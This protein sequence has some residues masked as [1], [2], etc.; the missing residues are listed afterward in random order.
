[1]S[2]RGKISIIGAGNVGATCAQRLVETDYADVVMV[3]I[4]EGLPQGKA[5]DIA[6]SAP[7]LG[8]NA[9]IAGT[10]DYR[11]TAGSDVVAITSG[12]ARKP[13]MTRDDLLRINMSIVGEV[14]KNVVEHSPEC[15]II[16]VTNPVE[17]MIYLALRTSHLP[18]RRVVG[19]SGVLDGARL[20][21]FIAAEL[22]AP[23]EAVSACVLGQHGE[24]MVVVPRLS[25]ANG[26][27]LT[28]LLPV[29][30]ANRLVQRTVGGGAEIVKL[31]KTGSAFYAPSASVA[32][33]AE[34]VILDKKEMLHCAAYLEGEYGMEGTVITVPVVLGSGG[35]EQI[36]E[37][38]LTVDERAQLA[39]SAG[40]VNQLIRAMRL[41]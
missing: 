37:L 40:A 13:G 33:M 19:L 27:S 7:V 36:V 3:D 34:A 14:V 29:E 41:G 25:T 38:E 16:M 6:Q 32:R 31:L 2:A 39:E 30:A 5:L 10:D 1:M 24:N 8:F 21:S 17:A 22:G 9:G 15:I 28:E 18:R 20:A 35:I 23:V 12:S 4:V 11:D 26:V